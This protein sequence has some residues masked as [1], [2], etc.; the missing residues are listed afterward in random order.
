M[1]TGGRT[2]KVRF[3][4]LGIGV[5]CSSASGGFRR[6]PTGGRTPRVAPRPWAMMC[7]AFS[8]G[9]I[10]E[11]A[12]GW[13]DTQGASRAWALVGEA[14][15]AS[16]GF[17]RM[18]TGGRTP[19]G[20][21]E[22]GLWWATPSASGGFRRMPTGGRTPRGALATLAMMCDAFSVKTD[23]TSWLSRSGRA[24]SKTG[25]AKSILLVKDVRRSLGALEHAGGVAGFGQEDGGCR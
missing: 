9:R 13:P 17:R 20:R 8:V 4:S 16:G 25:T 14:P 23:Q 15:S 7:D 24:R 5:R 10:P 1:P 12:H 19:R 22:P 3:A 18:P 2:P 11:D 6:M 21:R